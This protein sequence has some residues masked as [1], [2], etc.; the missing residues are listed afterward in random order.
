MQ[1]KDW[2]L[3]R[4]IIYSLGI[5]FL[6]FYLFMEFQDQKTLQRPDLI[7]MIHLSRYGNLGK[8]VD[9][10]F[11]S[12]KQLYL[13]TREKLLV[14]YDTF[15]CDGQVLNANKPKSFVFI[16]YPG[17]HIDYFS[18][19]SHEKD[20]YLLSEKLEQQNAATL[21]SQDKLSCR[22][23]VHWLHE[24][25][26]M[27]SKTE[28]SSFKP[29][30]MQYFSKGLLFASQDEPGFYLYNIEKKSWQPIQGTE[31]YLQ[32]EIVDFDVDGDRIAV[33]DKGSTITIFVYDEQSLG[34]LFDRSLNIPEDAEPC[35][36][37]LSLIFDSSYPRMVLFDSNAIRSHHFSDCGNNSHYWIS[38]NYQAFVKRVIV[39]EGGGFFIKGTM[40]S[41]EE[42][43][44]V[45]YPDSQWSIK[46]WA[47]P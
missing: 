45:S 24:F 21:A 36:G 46:M 40:D 10:A 34:F 42:I 3:L 23:H 7:N 30:K 27:N 15:I 16:N 19:V 9:S 20:L 44:F 13:T 12:N 17:N 14:Y 18:Y 43:F 29:Y 32:N 28:I 37:V 31:Q 11:I 39:N 8:P 22:Y 26:Y 2:S 25:N 5:L 1:N 38:Q 4:I 35:K 41:S 33:L 6:V 47:V